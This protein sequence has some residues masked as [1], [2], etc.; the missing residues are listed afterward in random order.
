[1]SKNLKKIIIDN[2]NLGS[3][4]EVA[5]Y[6]TQRNTGG[7]A[8]LRGNGNIIATNNFVLDDEVVLNF[9][10]NKNDL[11][12]F[13]KIYAR[14][15]TKGMLLVE[16]PLLAYKLVHGDMEN[17]YTFNSS[18]IAG[19]KVT[20][21]EAKRMTDEILKT[22]HFFAML[23]DF[24]IKSL[25]QTAGGFEI[26]MVLQT[27]SDL[28]NDDV[29]KMYNDLAKKQTQNQAFISID[30]AISEC[31]NKVQ[32]LKLRFTVTNEEI[33]TSEFGNEYVVKTK[34]EAIRRLEKIE[35]GEGTQEQKNELKKKATKELLRL[36]LKKEMSWLYYQISEFE[37]RMKN[38]IV[39][40]PIQGKPK[41]FKQHLGVGECYITVKI[42]MDENNAKDKEKIKEIK[43]LTSI[44]QNDIFTEMEFG[45][46]NALDLKSV[47]VA[48]VFFANDDESDSVIVS[49]I[50]A[51]N[52]YSREDLSI[53]NPKTIVE[54]T[55]ANT[56]AAFNKWLNITF[57]NPKEFKNYTIDVGDKEKNSLTM[58][59]LSHIYNEG[60]W[61]AYLINKQ[62]K[63][64]DY[65][66]GPF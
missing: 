13:C 17:M 20:K 51:A 8:P 3:N 5:S 61:Q 28:I 30:S 60:E 49:I 66:N 36:K 39:S 15:K 50:F 33:T 10:V 18:F 62:S 43:R 37:V 26:E 22:K 52:A 12:N 56:Y 53:Y 29:V 38:N 24:N 48:N 9:K 16:S 55:T 31:V 35:A 34:N 40:I 19:S 6:R 58:L 1:M 27:W 46:I 2:I 64:F 57:V 25:N 23:S 63:N 47:T 44:K 54:K 4:F 65:L 42:I 32:D 7:V 45:I 59:G 41:P 21:E 14:F 11:I